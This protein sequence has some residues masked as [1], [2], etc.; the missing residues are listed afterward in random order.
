L[1]KTISLTVNHADHGK[2][3]PRLRL[4]VTVLYCPETFS[5]STIS[6]RAEPPAV[7]QIPVRM[8]NALTPC[9]G[10]R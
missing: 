7:F 8:L 10:R 1:K 6:L 4:A 2:L 9:F 3:L 5:F